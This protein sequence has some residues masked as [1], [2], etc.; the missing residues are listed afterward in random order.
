MNLERYDCPAIS[1][2]LSRISLV[3]I[4][5]LLPACSTVNYQKAENSDIGYRD[6]Q[7]DPMTHFVEYT[8]HESV[9]WDQIHQFVRQRCA[10]IAAN[11]G[12]EFF[13]VLEKEERELMVD[14]KVSQIQVVSGNAKWAP[15]STDTYA[16]AGAKVKV[17]RVTYKIRLVK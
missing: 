4:C 5:F 11:R 16:M 2:Y 1:R 14:S 7:V 12:Y 6:V 8:E 17:K 13:D 3:L 15:P 10:E 9:P